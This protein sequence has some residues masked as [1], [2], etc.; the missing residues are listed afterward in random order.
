MATAFET[1]PL[2]VSIGETSPQ[3]DGAPADADVQPREM[4]STIGIKKPDDS[5]F[6]VVRFDE[7]QRRSKILRGRSSVR[8]ERF[9]FDKFYGALLRLLDSLVRRNK[10][11][12]QRFRAPERLSSPA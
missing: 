3:Y 2:G 6:E 12:L 10:K 1:M 11:P 4:S 7:V 8:G 5:V 9:A